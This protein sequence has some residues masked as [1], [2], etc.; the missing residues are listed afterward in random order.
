VLLKRRGV[1]SCDEVRDKA[2]DM[3]LDYGTGLGLGRVAS[4]Q[5]CKVV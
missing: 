2:G 1:V 4:L 3:G 5:S